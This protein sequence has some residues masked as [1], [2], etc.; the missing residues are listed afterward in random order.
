MND[1]DTRRFDMFVRAK[2]FGE[3]NATDFAVGGA[4]LTLFVELDGVIGKLETARATQNNSARTSKQSL[5]D[6]MRLDVQNII[7]TAAAIAQREPGFADSFRPPVSY[8][9]G[10]LM[11][12]TDKFLLQLAAQPGD[13]NAVATAKAAL[14][15]KFVAHEMNASFVTSLQ[16][17]RAAVTAARA[18]IET[19]RE[20]SVASTT[21]IGPLIAEGMEIV[22]TLDAI[23]H[24]KYG[25]APDRLAAWISASH[26]ERDPHSARTA[27][28]Q[29]PAAAK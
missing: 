25:A 11:M 14:V 6:A 1:R 18:Q 8:N 23:M 7:R 10:A 5:L 28:A 22:T 24:N 21:A 19:G 29:A 3:D 12:T 2:T 13:S 4:A 26:V 15:A 9:E 17:D 27:P 16:N 20:D